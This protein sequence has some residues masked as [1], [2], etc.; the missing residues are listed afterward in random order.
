[1]AVSQFWPAKDLL[2]PPAPCRRVAGVRPRTS[3]GEAA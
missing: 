2:D 1:M 3:L